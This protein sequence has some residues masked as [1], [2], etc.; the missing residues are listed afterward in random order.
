MC[1]LIE[2]AGFRFDRLETGYMGGPKPMTFM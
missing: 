1:P 2:A